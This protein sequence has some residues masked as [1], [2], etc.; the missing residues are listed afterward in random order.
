MPNLPDTDRP[1]SMNSAVDHR[2][3]LDDR[4]VAGVSRVENCAGDSREFVVES[5][6]S[7]NQEPN[8]TLVDQLE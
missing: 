8:P 1:Y 3:A 4:P 6:R 7:A 2:S 5:F